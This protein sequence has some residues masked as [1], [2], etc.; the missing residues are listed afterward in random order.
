MSDESLDSIRFVATC[1][2]CGTEC[3]L[4]KF[5][6]STVVG[7]PGC[8]HSVDCPKCKYQ[9]EI[10]EDNL[11]KVKLTPAEIELD[12]AEKTIKS[13][14]DELSKITD[15]R[16]SLRQTTSNLLT[17]SQKLLNMFTERDAIKQQLS[18]ITAVLATDKSD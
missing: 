17:I 1:P 7:L 6:Y 11:I 8:I 13:L 16:N 2:K 12:K 14:T 5:P 15:E 18:S 4:P 9:Y 3:R 10:R